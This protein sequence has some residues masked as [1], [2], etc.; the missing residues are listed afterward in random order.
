[1]TCQINRFLFPALIF[2]V[3]EI[4]LTFRERKKMLL[5]FPA[6]LW[7]KLLNPLVFY[8]EGGFSIYPWFPHPVK[9]E[10]SGSE[11]QLSAFIQKKPTVKQGPLVGETRCFPFSIFQCSKDLE[12]GLCIPSISELQNVS[13]LILSVKGI[14]ETRGTVPNATVWISHL[15]HP[16]PLRDWEVESGCNHFYSNSQDSGHSLG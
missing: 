11:P 13:H 16:L 7:P 15:C 10:S 6:F 12:N 3:P 9:E 2:P 4:M 5:L 1:M 14:N 8:S